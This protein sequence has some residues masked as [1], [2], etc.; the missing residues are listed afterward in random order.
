MRGESG[1]REVKGGERGARG[2][3]DQLGARYLEFMQ[4]KQLVN[5]SPCLSESGVM[6]LLNPVEAIGRLL[7]FRTFPEPSGEIGI[8]GA[9]KCPLAK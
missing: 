7:L 3:A 2:N 1:E 8:R 6:L 4:E 9:K 5:V